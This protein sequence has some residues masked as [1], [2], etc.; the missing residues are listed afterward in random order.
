M[1]TPVEKKPKTRRK[2]TWAPVKKHMGTLRL[3]MHTPK[4]G[5]CV[6]HL[7]MDYR[8][9]IIVRGGSMLNLVVFLGYS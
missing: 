1:A 6:I 9:I 8:G 4:P 5:T 2:N 3:A 7:L